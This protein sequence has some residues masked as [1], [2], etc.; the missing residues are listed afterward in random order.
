MYLMQAAQSYWRND[1]GGPAT[2]SS[3]RVQYS[4]VTT[5]FSVPMMV[6]VGYGYRQGS[7]HHMSAT[8]F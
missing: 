2:S 3:Q 6:E 1:V 5:E 7:W 4:G 8:P